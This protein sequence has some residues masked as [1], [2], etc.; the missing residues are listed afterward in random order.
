MELLNEAV[1]CYCY[2]QLSKIS[3][4]TSTSSSIGSPLFGNSSWHM[5]KVS[6]ELKRQLASLTKRPSASRR[7]D[8]TKSAAFHALKGLKFIG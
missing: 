2:V 4:S 3:S 8:H 5:K 1:V 6:E 7:F